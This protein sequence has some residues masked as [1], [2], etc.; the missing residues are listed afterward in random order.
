MGRMTEYACL[1]YL[2][3]LGTVQ[4]RDGKGCQQSDCKEN[5]GNII[6][7]ALLHVIRILLIVLVFVLVIEVSQSMTIR[8]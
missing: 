2:G 7:S 4:C 8:S 5:H 1:G 3:L 6:N